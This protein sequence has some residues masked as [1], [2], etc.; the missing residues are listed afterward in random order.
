MTSY[1]H[2]LGRQARRDRPGATSSCRKDSCKGPPIDAKS[3]DR[4]SPKGSL[5]D[6][7]I[8]V[9]DRRRP[10]RRRFAVG[11]VTD[12]QAGWRAFPPRPG[13]RCWRQPRSSATGRALIPQIMLNHRS[14][15]VAI[16]IGGMYNPFY[17]RVLE[18]FTIK[19]QEIGNQV[20]LVHVDSGHS[21]DAAIPRLASYRVDA[22]V[23]ALAVLSPKAADELARFKIPVVS[24]NTPVKN[25][26]VSSVSCDNE[27][28]ARRSPTCSSRAVRS[29]SAT[30]PARRAARPAR[31]ASPDSDRL[32]ELAYRPSDAAADFHY[33][34]GMRRA[35][36]CSK[37]GRSGP[38]RSSA[39]T[40]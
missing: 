14:H 34:G 32:A 33:E 19:L 40:T 36:A 29:G 8:R 39:P 28:A 5:Q 38:T 15:L 22:I 17:A 25:E 1:A 6:A 23:S 20:L 26:W 35:R 12:L 31:K 37:S 16:V 7:A 24:F 27:G 30:S 9:L 4:A 21:L 11:G 18:E 10:P 2:L 3:L 13:G